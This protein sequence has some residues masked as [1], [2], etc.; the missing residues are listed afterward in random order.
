ME[1]EMQIGIQSSL[2]EEEIQDYLKSVL[3][4]TGKK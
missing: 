2:S 1:L 3:S 4:K